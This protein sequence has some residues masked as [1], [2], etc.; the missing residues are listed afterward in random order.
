M[1]VYK[2]INLPSEYLLKYDKM[3]FLVNIRKI[4]KCLGKF[5]EEHWKY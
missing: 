2:Y 1:I 3:I 5:I 4:V